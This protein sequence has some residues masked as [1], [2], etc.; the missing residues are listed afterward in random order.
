MSTLQFLIR[1]ISQCF[2]WNICHMNYTILICGE[3]YLKDFRVVFA[4]F[5]LGLLN[6]PHHSRPHLIE[7]ISL[8]IIKF[9]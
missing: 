8:A 9:T 2:V 6:T 5:S 1:S 3:H 7:S 4:S